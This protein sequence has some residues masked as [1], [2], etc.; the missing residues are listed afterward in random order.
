VPEAMIYRERA[1]RV[2]TAQSKSRRISRSGLGLSALLAAVTALAA[3]APAASAH[4]PVAPVATSYLARIER[5]PARLEAKVVDGY[6]RLW[7]RV[8]ARTVVVILDYRGAPYLRFSRSGVAVNERSEMYYL[9]QTPY[10]LSPPVGLTA[11]TPPR[12]RLATSTHTYEWHDGRLQALASVA[13][14]PQT[15]YVG[16][17]RIPILLDGHRSAIGGGLWH[18]RSPSL[19]WFWPILVLFLCTLAALRVRSA[20]LDRRL[21]SA[22][23]PVALLAADAACCGRELHGRPGVTAFQH[24]ELAAVAAFSAWALLHLLRRRAGPFSFG[25]IAFLAIWQGLD[26][27]PTLVNHYV[28]VQLPASLAR[29]STILCLGC[30]VSLLLIAVVGMEE[31]PK[32]R[33]QRREATAADPRPR[34]EHGA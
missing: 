1:C 10:P 23:A 21:A 18:A 17:W 34:V 12:W 16:R 26:L 13:V 24:L 6:V 7:L 22:L 20:A 8:P 30:G 3:S 31:E 2:E 9:N 32:L 28:L 5:L 19:V 27:V 15:S 4:G 33:W 29:I 11:S 25:V 14:T